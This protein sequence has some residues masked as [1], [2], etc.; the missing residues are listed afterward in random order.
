[1]K[2]MNKTAA[3]IASKPIIKLMS[4]RE[5]VAI[6]SDLKQE[7]WQPDLNSRSHPMLTKHDEEG[8]QRFFT[9]T[10]VSDSKTN[11]SYMELEVAS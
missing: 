8:I 2:T 7:G 1:M 10:R 11:V 5:A 4:R 9:F 3:Y 6:W